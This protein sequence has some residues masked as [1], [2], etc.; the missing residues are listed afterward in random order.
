VT[1]PPIDRIQGTLD[2]L[3]LKSLV[4]GPMHGWA[5]SHHIRDT[6]REVLQVNQGALYPALRRLEDH[7]WV[8]ARWGV[9]DTNRRARFYTLTAAGRR[10]LAHETEGWLEFIRAVHRVMQ[11]APA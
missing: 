4:A 10:Q 5:I 9:S 8:T 6:S 2:M 3:I 11:L 1:A 7:G